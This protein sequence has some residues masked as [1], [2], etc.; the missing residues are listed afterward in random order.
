LRGYGLHF[1]G[2]WEQADPRIPHSPH[3]DMQVNEINTQES[4][5]HNENDDDDERPFHFIDCTMDTERQRNKK[6]CFG[7]SS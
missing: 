2:N 1:S 7:Y 4:A 5:D 6:N 3:R